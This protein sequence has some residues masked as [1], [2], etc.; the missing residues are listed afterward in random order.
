MKEKDIT[1]VT[2]ITRGR[3]KQLE[4]FFKKKIKIKN[5]PLSLSIQVNLGAFR[6]VFDRFKWFT[7]FMSV[8]AFG[9][10]E[11]PTTTTTA[12]K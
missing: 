8:T 5:G 7:S 12:K 3:K 1:Y 4:D 6:G 2:E 9:N 10:V 11:T